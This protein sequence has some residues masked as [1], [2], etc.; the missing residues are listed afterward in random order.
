MKRKKNTTKPIALKL[1]QLTTNIHC[2]SRLEAA[3]QV[4]L[5][6]LL[7]PRGRQCVAR[8]LCCHSNVKRTPEIDTIKFVT[9]F[10]LRCKLQLSRLRRILHKRFLATVFS[11]FARRF[12]CEYWHRHRVVAHSS[13]EFLL[14]SDIGPSHKYAGKHRLIEPYFSK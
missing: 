8:V 3:D 11:H 5:F 12:Q 6:R 7:P 4:F 2:T 13:Y 1:A 10:A 9:K 14:C